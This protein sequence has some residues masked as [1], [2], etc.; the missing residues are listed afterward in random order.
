MALSISPGGELTVSQSN[1]RQPAAIN[2]KTSAPFVAPT[3]AQCAM[4]TDVSGE[5]LL[6]VTNRLDS[7]CLRLKPGLPGMPISVAPKGSSSYKG[8]Y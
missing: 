7:P 4:R 1:G 5:Q 2:D 8:N 3:F 6:L